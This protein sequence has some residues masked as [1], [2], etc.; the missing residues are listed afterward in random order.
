MK[1]SSV[2][3]KTFSEAS[4][5]ALDDAIVAWLETDAAERVFVSIHFEVDGATFAAMLV[6]TD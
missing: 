1:L 4:A 3:T 5:V 2:K 6:Y